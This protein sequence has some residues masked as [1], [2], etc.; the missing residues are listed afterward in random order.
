MELAT[1]TPKMQARKDAGIGWMTFNNPERHNAVSMEMWQAAESILADFAED[2]EVRVIVLS[3]AGGK[4]FVSGADISKF[5]S[6]RSSAEAVAAYNA[7][8]ER[9][10]GGL[11]R[12]AKPVI[13]MIEGHCIGGG[14]AL[15]TCCDIRICSENSSF[16]IPAA[17]LGLGYGLKGVSRLMSLIGPSYTKELFFTAR[18]FT[19]AE[20]ERMGLVNR[21]L[22]R[23]EVQDFV[24]T[25]AQ[26]I[27]ANAPLTVTSIKRI[28][29]EALKDEATR[30]TALCDQLVAEC[31]GSQDYIEGRRAFLEKRKPAFQ[32]R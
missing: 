18:R 13:A 30:D 26:E 12:L 21:V 23:G 14:V 11:Y 1:T 10:Y 6:E 9:V 29:G 32:G 27:A 28:V 25:M 31:F 5:E 2:P 19:A 4:A 24:A 17:R 8:T 15:A 20:A 7:Q 3:G 22:P 16:G